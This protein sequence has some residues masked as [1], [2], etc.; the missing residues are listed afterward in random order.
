M[1]IRKNISL[2]CQSAKIEVME[3]MENAVAFSFVSIGT[4]VRIAV[5]IIFFEAIYLQVDEIGGWAIE[6]V[7]VLLETF[8]LIQGLAWASYTRGFNKIAR[9]IENGDLDVYL[10]KPVNLQAFLS[11][12]FIDLIFTTPQLL[13][14]LGSVFYGMAKSD[15][16][17]NLPLYFLAMICA[18]VIHYSVVLII[19][20]SNFFVLNHQIIF[21]RE[22]LLNLGRYPVVIYKGL[23]QTVLTFVIPVAIIFSFPVRV[24]FGDVTLVE[25]FT[26]ILMA[27]IFFLV[28]QLV[29]FQGLNRY[30]SAKG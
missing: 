23:A 17:I 9:Y 11:Y 15:F 2:L 7:Y 28:S 27:I 29:W 24:F 12:R 4:I 18:I 14:G 30:E 16:L 5:L 20:S 3:R 6:Q 13:V 19:S 10:S 21:L 25:V 8:F 22:E 26:V 1:N